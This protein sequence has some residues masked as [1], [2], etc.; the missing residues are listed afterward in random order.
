MSCKIDPGT[1]IHAHLAHAETDSTGGGGMSVCG[2][3]ER[4]K[5]DAQIQTAID[6]GRA[7]DAKSIWKAIEKRRTVKINGYSIGGDTVAKK[8]VF[9]TPSDVIAF[10][11]ADTKRRHQKISVEMVRAWPDAGSTRVMLTAEA[12][13]MYK[14]NLPKW[15]SPE[16]HITITADGNEIAPRGPSPSGA[17]HRSPAFSSVRCTSESV[18]VRAPISPSNDSMRRIVP[19][20]TRALRQFNLFH[21]EK[22]TCS[23]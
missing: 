2:G 13:G 16:V 21:A 5:T 23:A 20:A 19:R 11:A 18:P 3:G 17:A 8:A 10:A 4:R 15:Q 9:M 1:L 7:S 14:M 6:T 22:R 12:S